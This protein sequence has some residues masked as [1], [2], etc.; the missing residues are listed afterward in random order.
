MS[1]DMFPLAGVPSEVSFK[2]SFRK[3]PFQKKSKT[4]KEAS[5]MKQTRK[6]RLKLRKMASQTP[7]VLEQKSICENDSYK[8]TSF[9]IRCPVIFLVVEREKE[10]GMVKIGRFSGLQ[11][12]GGRV[13]S[14][15]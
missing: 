2:R 7:P 5:Q 15:I 10:E 13:R 9:G 8:L 3:S 4:R 12:C 14:V 1:G 11:R 6:L